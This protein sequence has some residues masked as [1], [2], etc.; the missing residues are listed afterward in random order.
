M[1]TAQRDFVKKCS[2]TNYA[3]VQLSFSNSQDF[4]SNDNK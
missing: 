2:E 4:Y 3:N 1:S